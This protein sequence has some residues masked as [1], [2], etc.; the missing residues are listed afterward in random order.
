[1]KGIKKLDYAFYRRADVLAIARDLIGKLLVTRVDQVLTSGRIVETEAYA[2]PSDK[3]SHA[4]GNRKSTRTGVMYREG[5]CAYVYLCYGLHHL[6]NVVTNR[7]G[8]PHAVLIRAL[9]P[10]SGLDK[11]AERTGKKSGDISLTRGPGNLSRALGLRHGMSGTDLCGQ[12]IFIADDGTA[13]PPGSI[14][15]TPRIGVGYAAEDAALPYRFIWQ[16]NKYVSG[17]ISG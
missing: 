2:G 7:E 12:D 17:K 15:A 1:M 10:V 11:M 8:I 16:G 4:Y 3:A 6:F 5:G 9:E 13:V 14:L